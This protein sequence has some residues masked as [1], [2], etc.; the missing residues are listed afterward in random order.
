MIAPL[1]RLIPFLFAALL[2][3]AGPAASQEAAKPYEPIPGQPGKDV[4][5]VPTS[6]ELLKKMLDMAEVTPRDFV[7]DLGS[8]DGR[9]VIA[10]ARR[11]ARALGVEYEE[12]LVELARRRAAAAGVSERAVFV[13]GDMFDADISEA[14][15]LALFLLTENLDILAPKFLDLKPGT[16]I[17]LNYFLVSGWLPERS[18]TVGRCDAWCTAH[19][20]IVP[21]KVEGAWQLE[22]ET[23]S[24]RQHFQMVEGTLTL[25]G[26]PVGIARGRLHGER[27]VFEAGG[28]RYEG[29]VEG[30]RIVGERTGAAGGPW[31]ATR[32]R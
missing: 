28:T 6:D 19:L 5:W 21:A 25:G 20:Y 30:D 11:G 1:F 14:T 24:L 17:A 7:M 4:V 16:R 27:I 32:A 26:K 18:E 2:L 23:L 8:G 13:H 9:N 3:A 31:V 12:G 15:V 29:R 10:A 22:G